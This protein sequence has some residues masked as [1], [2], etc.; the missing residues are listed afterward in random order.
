ML[1]N[2]LN[3]KRYAMT[4]VRQAVAATAPGGRRRDQPV[5]TRTPITSAP[6]EDAWRQTD[7]LVRG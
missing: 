6:T 7:V 5:D 1:F 2:V 4:R 3:S